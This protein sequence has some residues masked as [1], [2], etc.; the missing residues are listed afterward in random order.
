M[1]VNK[2]G[3]F[4][5]AGGDIPYQMQDHLIH[6]SSGRFTVFAHFVLFVVQPPTA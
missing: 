4:R 2:I 1:C 3:I 6:G 5:P